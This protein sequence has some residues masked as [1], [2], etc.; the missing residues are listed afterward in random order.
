MQFRSRWIVGLCLGVTLW[1]CTDADAGGRRRGGGGDPMNMDLGMAMA[2]DWSQYDSPWGPSVYVE[3]GAMIPMSGPWEDMLKSGISTAIGVR[4]KHA[5]WTGDLFPAS[6]T[7]ISV[8]HRYAYQKDDEDVQLYTTGGFV[9]DVGNMHINLLEVG[10]TQRFISPTRRGFFWDVGAGLG[11]GGA[12]G[13]IN[14]AVPD[15]FDVPLFISKRKEDAFMIRGE[16]NTGV[17]LQIDRLDLRFG[18]ATGVSG[19]S[20]LT[21]R[22]TTNTDFGVRMGGTI[23][24]F[25]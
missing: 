9:G 1:A 19:S 23:F 7:Y 24:L 5:D 20:A 18:L 4:W 25:D 12:N 2:I 13:R 6:S 22:F 16:L 10:V 11:V 21:G 3:Y 17:G 15:P 14:A 8:G